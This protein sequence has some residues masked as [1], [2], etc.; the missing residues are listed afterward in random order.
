MCV[1]YGLS[2]KWHTA[3][4]VASTHYAVPMRVLHPCP[5]QE[6]PHTVLARRGYPIP[7]L[8][9]GWVPNPVLAKG[10]SLM[11]FLGSSF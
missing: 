3:R 1:L 2:R 7:V 5:G 8:A 9:G 11:V 6:V 4:R 10:V